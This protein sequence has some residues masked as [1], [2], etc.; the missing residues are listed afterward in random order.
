[1]NLLNFFEYYYPISPLTKVP[2]MNTP[3]TYEIY[4]PFVENINTADIDGVIAQSYPPHTAYASFFDAQIL[5][6]LHLVLLNIV[7][8]LMILIR[9]YK[10]VSAFLSHIQ[11]KF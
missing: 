11:L 3:L 2:L 7:G 5:S 1:M 8:S 9:R 10:V 6:M 4:S